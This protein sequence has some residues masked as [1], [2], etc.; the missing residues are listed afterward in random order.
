M[1]FTNV[2]TKEKQ[3]SRSLGAQEVKKC[4]NV[5]HCLK[6]FSEHICLPS[7]YFQSTYYVLS[8]VLGS[9]RT[10]ASK[11]LADFVEGSDQQASVGSELCSVL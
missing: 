11:V 4:K 10:M 3:L 5:T 1:G 2:L 6:R 7:R 9:L 8:T